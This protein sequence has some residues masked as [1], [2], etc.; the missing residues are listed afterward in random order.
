MNATDPRRHSPAAE[1]NRAAILTELLRRLPARGMALEVAS[2][3]GQHISHF[4]AALPGWTWQASD[5]D[6]GALASITALSQDSGLP[7]LLPPQHLDLLAAVPMAQDRRR[8]LVAAAPGPCL[9]RQP[10]PHRPLGGLQRADAPRSRHVW[11]PTG[12]LV[13]Y[14]PYRVDGEPLQ[15]GNQ[16]FDADLRQRNPAWGL[17]WL[18]EVVAEATGRRPG[19]G[20]THR[21][22]GQQPAAGLRTGRGRQALPGA[23]RARAGQVFDAPD[24]QTLLASGRRAGLELPSA[25]RAGTC[26]RCLIR[27]TG[28]SVRYTVDWPGLSAEERAEGWVLPCV[29]CPASDLVVS[30]R[31]AACPPAG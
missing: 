6:P 28:G 15:P 21:H 24:R 27:L 25:C 1:R 20:R 22:A 31:P 13:M 17:R 2:G 19:A 9:L 29:A 3:T 30:F 23:G 26:R 16:A 4:A 10:D 5:A 8:R 11:R 14:G 7:N 18:H 12:R